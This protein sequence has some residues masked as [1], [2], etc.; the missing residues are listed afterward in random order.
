MSFPHLGGVLKLG[1]TSS[2]VPISSSPLQKALSPTREGLLERAV[3][4]QQYHHAYLPSSSLACLPHHILPLGLL[5]LIQPLVVAP[6][7]F[8]K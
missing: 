8:T 3:E 4:Y 1:F 5:D 7:F 2:F 6:L